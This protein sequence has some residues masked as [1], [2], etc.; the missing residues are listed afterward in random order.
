MEFDWK[1][2]ENVSERDGHDIGFIAQQLEEIVPTAV[3]TR[4]D[5]YKTVKYE[6]VVPIL[7]QAIKEQQSLIEQLTARIEAL[8]N[9]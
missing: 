5:G 7:V 6:K 9:R 1:P 3:H 8:E 4:S 2:V